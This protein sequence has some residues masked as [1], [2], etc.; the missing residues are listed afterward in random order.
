ME[1]I[2]QIK[3][4][5]TAKRSFVLEAGAGAGKTYALI[6]TI[7]YLIE[8]Q[9]KSLTLNNQKIV[10]ITYTNVAKN[11]IIERLENNP[12]VLVS[13]IH[14][15][16]WDCIKLFNK[17]LIIEFD[18]INTIKHEEK[19]ENFTLG[20]AGRIASVDYSDRAYSDFEKGTVG[21]DD[22]ITLSKRMFQNYQ[23]LTS[24]L[25]S[26]YPYLLVDEYQ[27]TA[28][29]TIQALLDSLLNQHYETVVVG[30]FGD[31]HQK[32]YD[33]GIGSLQEYV[34][35]GAIDIIKKE[36]NYRSSKAVIDLLNNIRTNIEQKT[37][38]EIET[39]EGS[40]KFYNCVN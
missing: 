40:V 30:F 18:A 16:L 6:Q 32:I 8:T 19:P 29:E 22:F 15:F 38:D 26:K 10:C 5:I 11:E 28:L 34:I 17:Q 20:L 13:T 1:A 37:P 14:E 23:L 4:K 9:G 33:T 2:D 35:S 3:E 31:S 7:N 25:A 27:D 36:E 24:I 21:H 12:L 39:V